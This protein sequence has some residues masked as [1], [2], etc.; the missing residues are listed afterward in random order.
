MYKRDTSIPTII[1]EGLF[2]ITY[3]LE[4]SPV[5]IKEKGVEN[6][7]LIV[8]GFMKQQRIHSPAPLLA[9]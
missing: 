2:Q 7:L 3:R 4:F 1:F 8:M 9:A 6:R 5:N